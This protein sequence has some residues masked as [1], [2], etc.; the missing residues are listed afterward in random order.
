MMAFVPIKK[1]KIRVISFHNYPMKLKTI[2][3]RREPPIRAV[4]IETEIGAIVSALR[5]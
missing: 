5:I 3:L 1:K 4:T 2:I